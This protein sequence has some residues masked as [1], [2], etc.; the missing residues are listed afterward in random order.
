MRART[1]ISAFLIPSA[2]FLTVISGAA[3][4]DITLVH[5]DRQVMAFAMVT[6]DSGEH[7]D[8][9]RMDM[10]MF[11]EDFN[12]SALASVAAIGGAA[13][14]SAGQLSSITGGAINLQGSVS[15]SA[16]VQTPTTAMAH[17]H[18][19][20]DLVFDIS[21]GTHVELIASMSGSAMIELR[22]GDETL[23]FN[24][25][26][27][28]ERTFASATRLHLFAA[29]FAEFEAP[30]QTSDGG[31]YALIFNAVPTPGTLGVAGVSGLLARRRRR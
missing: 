27:F 29:A 10:A 17:G 30:G 21:A 23:L 16:S 8:G 14:C 12:G 18:S 24:G 26:G 31:A 5:D 22:L 7:T 15:A 11:G 2:A 19:L 28:F 1:P 9:P 13:G 4:A 20:G 25:S 6:N 3:R